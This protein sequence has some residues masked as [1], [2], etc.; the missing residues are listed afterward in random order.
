MQPMREKFYFRTFCVQ[1]KMKLID[2]NPVFGKVIY[3]YAYVYF[4]KNVRTLR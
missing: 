4:I 2:L 3:I 1:F